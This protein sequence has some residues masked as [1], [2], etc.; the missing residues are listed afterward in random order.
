VTGDMRLTAQGIAFV[1]KTI[2][3]PA[4]RPFTIAFLNDDPGTPHDVAFKDDAGGY[5]WRGEPITGIATKVYDVPA[6]PAGSYT[7]V[8]TIHSNMTGTA[9]LK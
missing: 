6:L 3:G 1:E 7:F 4:D 2:D 5:A 8:C 9:T